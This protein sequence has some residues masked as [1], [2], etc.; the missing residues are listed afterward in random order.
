MPIDTSDAA[1]A[2]PAATDEMVS[3]PGKVTDVH[4]PLARQVLRKLWLKVHLYL[5]L[6]VGGLFVLISLTGSL[7]VF[8]KAIDEWL[9]PEL[10]RSSSAG[11]SR[12]LNEIVAA[13]YAA[14]PERGRLETI[15]LPDHPGDTVLVW[16][17][18]PTHDPEEPR[19]IEVR[20]DPATA[21][22]LS[23]DREWGGTLVSVIYE[24]HE[25]LLIEKPGQTIVGFLAL[26]LLVS[27]GTGLYLW[28]PSLGR[29]RQS[30]SFNPGRSVIRWHYDAHKLS[31]LYSAVILA[32]LA[33]T[34][35]YLEFSEYVVPLV[36][37]FS[38]VQELPKKGELRSRPPAPSAQALSAEQAVA[39]AREIFP[40]GE[41]KFLAVPDNPEGIFRIGLRQPGEVRESSGQSQVWLDQYS[42]AVLHLRD[43]R[44]FTA[45]DT[46][47]AWLFPL[48]NGEAF[49]LAVRWIV[50]VSGFVPL[51]LYV[52]GL[53]M[54]WLKRRAH[55]RQ[56]ARVNASAAQERFA[57]D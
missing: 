9:N 26:F 57:H 20:I 14:R 6:I 51:V 47:V 29:L 54:W 46:F 22:V 55:L 48:H 24:L 21:E 10:V 32:M 35:V 56:R 17:T 3:R 33:F 42:G 34:G 13:A 30:F 49:G 23:R 8:Y 7:L 38:P 36:R 40:N 37:V 18:I 1:I 31:G 50:C 44:N 53:R 11:E 19:W 2:Q 25:S 4:L 15:R 27:I 39:L 45:G 5:G 12:P 28:W 52:T 41:L 43:W 16:Y